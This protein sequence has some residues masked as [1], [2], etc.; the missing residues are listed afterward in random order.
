[1][2]KC[3]STRQRSGCETAACKKNWQGHPSL[4]LP[5]FAWDPQKRLVFFM[6]RRNSSS[7]TSPSPSRSASSIISCSSSSV[8]LSP[9]SL[10]TLFKFLKLISRLVIIEE[11]ESFQD[12]VLWISVQDLVCHHLEEFF[13]L[14]GT[15][16]IIIDVRNHFLNFLFLGLEAKC[17]HCNLELL[18]IDGAT[19]IGI[20]EVKGLLD[21]L[22]LLLGKLLLLLSTGV[23]TTESHIDREF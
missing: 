11:A 23:E 5:Q 4:E 16:S 8:I 1:M 17:A 13:I 21:F 15:T 10:A 2:S 12:F 3:Y 6:I 22:L 19:A 18:G 14:N 7:F 9:S 20:E